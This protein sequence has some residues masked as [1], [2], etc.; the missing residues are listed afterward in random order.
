[1]M[2]IYQNVGWPKFIWDNDRLLSTLS[3]VRNLQGRIIVTFR[4]VAL[5][6]L[7]G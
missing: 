6:M 4:P 7:S 2:F 1:M 3:S 5:P